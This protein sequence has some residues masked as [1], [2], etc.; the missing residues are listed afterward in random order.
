[1]LSHL[2][3]KNSDPCPAYEKKPFFQSDLKSFHADLR[4]VLPD[5]HIFPQVDLAALIAPASKDPRQ[6]RAELARLQGRKVDYAVFDDQLELLFVIELTPQG[7][8]QDDAASN[9]SYLKFAGIKSICW[10]LRQL[11]S[12]DQIRRTLLPDLCV[13]ADGAPA[14]AAPAN[15]HKTADSAGA[16]APSKVRTATTAPKNAGLS[17]AAIEGLT[18]HGRIKAA[19]PHIWERICLFCSEPVHLEKYLT[20]LSIQDRGGARTGLLP[21]VI[22]EITAIQA[23][24]QRFLQVL[25]PDTRW[26]KLSTTC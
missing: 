3:K 1:M 13:V 21:D 15:G 7:Y 12:A 22:I 9:A 14:T 10:S 8:S 2:F 4:Q 18:R 26:K 23:A 11:P 16:G 19:Y 25:K 20:S 6:Q 24:N 5:Y 17:V